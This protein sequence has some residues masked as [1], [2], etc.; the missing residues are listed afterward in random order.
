MASGLARAMPALPEALSQQPGRSDQ[1]PAL[2]R[3]IIWP[4]KTPRR[5]A[6]LALC[7]LGLRMGYSKMLKYQIIS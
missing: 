5:H 7:L 1:E 2:L 4:G 3:R 6:S